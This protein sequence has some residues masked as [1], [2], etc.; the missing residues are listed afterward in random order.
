[1]RPGVVG[2]PLVGEGEEDGVVGVVDVDE[3]HD[4]VEEEIHETFPVTV[5]P[6]RW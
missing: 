5:T 6:V 2:P 3:V 4:E 1:M